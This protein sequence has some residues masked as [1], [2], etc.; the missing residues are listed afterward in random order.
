MYKCPWNKLRSCTQV[1]EREKSR[2]KVAVCGWTRTLV[3]RS[4]G[5]ISG[6]C[7]GSFTPLIGPTCAFLGR[8]GNLPNWGRASHQPSTYHL[9]VGIEWARWWSV[10][11]FVSWTVPVATPYRWQRR[12]K[13]TECLKGISTEEK[14]V[15]FYERSLEE[16]MLK[17]GAGTP[18]GSLDYLTKSVERKRSWTGCRIWKH[19]DI[20]ASLLCKQ[21]WA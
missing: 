6:R 4:M 14:V 1:G 13:R 7:Q 17:S 21:R 5:E 8:I 18:R 15:V 3:G 11:P 19:G 12:R 16:K 9:S 2:K 20:C 10:Y